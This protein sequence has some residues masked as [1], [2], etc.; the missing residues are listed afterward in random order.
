MNENRSL[1]EGFSGCTPNFKVRGPS[2]GQAEAVRTLRLS[3][4]NLLV[5]FLSRNKES[6][7]AGVNRSLLARIDMTARYLYENHCF[8]N[9]H[10]GLGYSLELHRLMTSAVISHDTDYSSGRIVIL[11]KSSKGYH[12]CYKDLTEVTSTAVF[13]DVNTHE[14]ALTCV[15]FYSRAT[16]FS[17]LITGLA[18]VYLLDLRLS[19]HDNAYSHTVNLYEPSVFNAQKKESA[20]E[21]LS[22]Y[23]SNSKTFGNSF[24]VPSSVNDYCCRSF[25]NERHIKTSPSL[26][27]VFLINWS[28][29]SKSFT[30][31]N[32]STD[33][34]TTYSSS[35]FFD[36]VQFSTNSTE[37]VILYSNR[38][39]NNSLVVFNLKTGHFSKVYFSQKI[40]NRYFDMYSPN[41]KISIITD[42][43]RV[44]ALFYGKEDNLVVLL[45]GCLILYKNRGFEK[46]FLD[47]HTGKIIYELNNVISIRETLYRK[48]NSLVP[49]YG[50]A[51]YRRTARGPV[52]RQLYQCVLHCSKE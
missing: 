50:S 13:F 38:L 47:S 45:N 1:D 41:S 30:C 6:S 3:Q 22:V 34:V 35:I 31:I 2:D 4:S 52:P 12:L 20:A 26:N 14:V 43:K 16:P 9:L 51:R 7:L 11:V 10:S 44:E 25:V 36:Q 29:L 40:I 23:Q 49:A 39:T 32:T 5:H 42:S 24:E 15:K 19:A 37:K 46:D 33:E 27:G 18:R 48:V 8:L 21:R 28:F 17:V